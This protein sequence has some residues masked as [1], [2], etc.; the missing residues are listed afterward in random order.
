MAKQQKPIQRHEV[1]I[2]RGYICTLP[3]RGVE[4]SERADHYGIRYKPIE[5]LWAPLVRE[6]QAEL[7]GDRKVGCPR[8]CEHSHACIE[9]GKEFYNAWE[10]WPRCC[11]GR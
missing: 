2:A 4:R 7:D 3:K 1:L 8:P 11:A 10:I 6:L 9:C 5:R